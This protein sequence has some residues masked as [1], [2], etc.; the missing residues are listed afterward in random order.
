MQD[1]SDRPDKGKLKSMLKR[2][3][4]GRR[5]ALAVA[6][7]ELDQQ[8]DAVERAP[9]SAERLKAV[10]LGL[11][12]RLKTIRASSRRSGVTQDLELSRASF[13]D[14]LSF[15]AAR[16]ARQMQG[17]DVGAEVEKPSKWVGFKRKAIS[18]VSSDGRQK[19]GK[20]KKE[21]AQ[22]PLSEKQSARAERIREDAEKIKQRVMSR[23]PMKSSAAL[24]IN[25]AVFGIAVAGAWKVSEYGVLQAK[26][27][28]L[29]G[30]AVASE[31]APP[32]VLSEL[33][34]LL[35][36]AAGDGTAGS[37][38]PSESQIN[39]I[40]DPKRLMTPEELEAVM[41]KMGLDVNGEPLPEPEP[42]PTPPPVVIDYKAI[43]Q[44]LASR[45]MRIDSV[46]PGKGAFINGRWHAVGELVSEGE[47]EGVRVKVV[48]AEAGLSAA[49][50]RF[51]GESIKLDTAS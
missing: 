38:T 25:I 3:R 21:K 48:L 36:V 15:E 9:T 22:N 40:F 51:N 16:M 27:Q 31:A 26:Q 6:A 28:V 50:L 4:A 1:E 45:T 44:A 30:R 8:A 32:T 29:L 46:V 42:E 24:A 7:T 20:V 43:F 10:V 14:D 12:D 17:T 39:S 5:D 11:S 2:L 35:S 13:P 34:L 18:G 49:I 37:A 33:P 19:K 41:A 23:K 47:H